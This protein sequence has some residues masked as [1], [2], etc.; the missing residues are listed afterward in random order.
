M[1]C[2]K[3]LKRYQVPGGHCSIINFDE[4]WANFLCFPDLSFLVCYE[5]DWIG[6]SLRALPVLEF[7]FQVW[8]KINCKDALKNAKIL[9]KNAVG[10]C[11][12]YIHMLI[13]QSCLQGREHNASI[14]WGLWNLERHLFWDCF[15]L[16]GEL[17][18]STVAG[19]VSCWDSS[20]TWPSWVFKQLPSQGSLCCFLQNL[21]NW[22]LQAR[23]GV[24]SLLQPEKGLG[25]A[26][27]CRFPSK[28]IIFCCLPVNTIYSHVREAILL[29]CTMSITIVLL[30]RAFSWP[31]KR[32]QRWHL[33]ISV[34]WEGHSTAWQ[35]GHP[36]IYL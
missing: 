26:D 33:R 14:L 2:F 23:H 24:T 30:A 32:S 28:G 12:T 10:R 19:E 21:C 36:W 11:L 35:S 6:I 8:I 18:G 4:S 20:C 3:F 17:S 34:S 27:S 29:I 31:M 15:T 1:L 16:R 7:L 13:G 9:S 22:N 5:K 25:Q